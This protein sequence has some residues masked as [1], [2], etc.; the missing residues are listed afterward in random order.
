VLRCKRITDCEKIKNQEIVMQIEVQYEDR[1]LRL[2]DGIKFKAGLQKILIDVPDG[3]LED[4]STPTDPVLDG[5]Y[6]ML[7]K[8][9]IY[10]PSGKSDQELLADALQ[11]KYLK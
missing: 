2:P 4:Q 11:E 1:Y 7:G 3:V 10:R 6:K 9:Y 5:L 8:D